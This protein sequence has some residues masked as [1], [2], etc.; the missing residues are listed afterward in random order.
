MVASVAELLS[1]PSPQE[2]LRNLDNLPG[3]C[4]N[5]VGETP[6]WFFLQGLDQ[7]PYSVT[8]TQRE[9]EVYGQISLQKRNYM[10]IKKNQLLYESTY[11]KCSDRQI[12]RDRK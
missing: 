10:P 8:L 1:P 6:P 4:V 12:Y 3:F 11:M 9:R 2:E 5:M 7:S